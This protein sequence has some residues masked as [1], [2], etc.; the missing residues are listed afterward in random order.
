MAWAVLQSPTATAN[1]LLLLLLLL[2]LP[3]LTSAQTKVVDCVAQFELANR[4]CTIIHAVKAIQGNRRDRGSEHGHSH[5][6][7]EGEGEDEGKGHHR[8]RCCRWL[9]EIDDSCVC[10]ALLHLPISLVKPNHKYTVAVGHHCSITYNCN[11]LYRG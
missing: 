10:N 6:H 7:G 5:R 9:K 8:N 11:R 1:V 2:L 3:E 4:A